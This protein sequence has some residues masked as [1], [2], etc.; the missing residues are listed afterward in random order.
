MTFLLTPGQRHEAAV[1]VPLRQQGAVKRH[2]PGRPKRRP[3]RLVGDKGESR[4]AIRQYVRQHGIRLTMPRKRWESRTGLF[5]RTLYRFRNAVA[6]LI[7]R[8]K[9]CRRMA[10]REEK[11]A[12]N[13]H[14]RL[15]MA[16]IVRWL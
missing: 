8:L 12:E 6:R 14:A 4:R 15:L 10:T 3:T 1:F 16:A 2:G 13:D 9:Q 7:N 5:D 11:R